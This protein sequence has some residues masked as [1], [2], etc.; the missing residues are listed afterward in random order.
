[1]LTE[2]W[3]LNIRFYHPYSSNLAARLTYTI[4]FK[5]FERAM[6]QVERK[7]AIKRPYQA[8]PDPYTTTRHIHQG[9]EALWKR[10]TPHHIEITNGSGEIQIYYAVKLPY[11]ERAHRFRLCSPVQLSV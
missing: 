1:L 3:G 7:Y 10:G 4:D 5:P 11:G 6:I 2:E 8:T 9:A